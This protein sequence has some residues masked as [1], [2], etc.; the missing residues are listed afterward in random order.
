MYEQE[1]QSTPKETKVN[2]DKLMSNQ[3]KKTKDTVKEEVIQYVKPTVVCYKDS[4]IL[5]G[6]KQSLPTTKEYLMKEY[7]NV[8][9]GIGTLP[10]VPY[11][12]QLKENYTAVHHV[13]HQVVVSLKS[14]YKAELQRLMNA[15]IITEVQ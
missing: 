11:H 9:S 6:K 12:V 15:G 13:P 4:I 14:A 1:L 8:F 2:V 3:A 7:K 5:N 10:G